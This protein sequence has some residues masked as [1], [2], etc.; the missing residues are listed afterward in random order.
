MSK[1]RIALIT[2]AASGIGLASAELLLK[3]GVTVVMADRSESVI[4]IARDLAASTGGSATGFVA[5]LSVEANVLKLARDVLAQFGAVDILVNNAG[6]H[7]KNGGRKFFLEEITS[8][9]WATVLA[10]NLT[11][12]FLLSRE[13]LPQMKARGWGRVIN[14]SSNSARTVVPPTSA[15]YVTSKHGIIG[16]THMTAYE[17]APHGVTVNAVAPGPVRT[18][19]TGQSSPENQAMIEKMVPM[20]RYGDPMELAVVIRFLASDASSFITGAVF[21]VNGG[22]VII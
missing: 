14:I 21:D 20:G 22:S 1:K 3:D 11:A 9:Q 12:P 18:G 15:A 16:L 17:Y 13:L 4:S 10:I 2:G 5:E 19:L 8:E 6:V 7:P